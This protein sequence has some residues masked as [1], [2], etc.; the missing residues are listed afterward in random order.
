MIYKL[1]EAAS[2][3]NVSAHLIC[4]SQYDGAVGRIEDVNSALDNATEESVTE[5]RQI[6]SN[7]PHLLVEANDAEAYSSTS[8]QEYFEL[9]TGSCGPVGIS[10]NSAEDCQHHQSRTNLRKS[11]LRQPS[12]HLHSDC[13]SLHSSPARSSSE[14]HSAPS[15]SRS[16]TSPANREVRFAFHDSFEW[17]SPTLSKKYASESPHL[18]DSDCEIYT[19]DEFKQKFCSENTCRT[20][21]SDKLGSQNQRCHICIQE[22]ITSVDASRKPNEYRETY[23][24]VVERGPRGCSV[25]RPTLCTTSLADSH[26]KVLPQSFYKDANGLMMAEVTGNQKLI[27]HPSGEYLLLHLSV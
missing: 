16:P 9:T 1:E 14:R 12:S 26:S 17:D 5:G 23:T 3:E 7:E 22:P 19:W 11:I 25:Y 20:C 6:C 27:T 18:I 24:C 21:E 10:H 13:G 8:Q 4:D 2:T 15:S